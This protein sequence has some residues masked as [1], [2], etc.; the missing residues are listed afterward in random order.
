MPESS[1]SGCL[2]PGL[3]SP[4]HNAVVMHRAAPDPDAE[5]IR[6]PD[7]RLPT[8]T[9]LSTYSACLGTAR[10]LPTCPVGNHPSRAISD[11]SH[12]IS[13]GGVVDELLAGTI[14]SSRTLTVNGLQNHSFIDGML[15]RALRERGVDDPKPRPGAL[16]AEMKVR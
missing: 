15:P 2:A 16:G 3:D 13:P 4:A 8:Q 9:T 1:Q 11:E 14:T 7:R 10:W 6:G 5:Q 12:L